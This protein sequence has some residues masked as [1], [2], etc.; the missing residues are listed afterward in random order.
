MDNFAFQRL[1]LDDIVTLR[2]MFVCGYK[3]R[4]SLLLDAITFRDAKAVS[5]ILRYKALRDSE[6]AKA[7]TLAEESYNNAVSTMNAALMVAETPK[8]VRGKPYVNH[9]P[10]MT[11]ESNLYGGRDAE[12]IR[13]LSGW[14]GA[15]GE[16]G[17]FDL[18]HRRT[19]TVASHV[20]NNGL[21]ATDKA[22]IT[23]II[24]NLILYGNA[25]LLEAM[26]KRGHPITKK[27][28]ADCINF[29]HY[30]MLEVVGKY[31]QGTLPK[32]AMRHITG[33]ATKRNI[34]CNILK[35]VTP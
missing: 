23:G 18:L 11:T 4:F 20:I 35:G 32:G 21:Y 8:V 1:V 26:L 7:V 22:S 9:K 33:E 16:W 15:I 13:T 34:T 10:L 14:D 27:Q 25:V 19:D 6:R 24:N 5:L 12:V 3:P 31:Y 30:T 2:L 17:M 29:E 28:V